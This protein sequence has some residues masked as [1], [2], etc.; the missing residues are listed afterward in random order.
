M[1]IKFNQS[2]RN[3]VIGSGIMMSLTDIERQVAG[4]SVNVDTITGKAGITIW[5]GSQPTP[6]NII[7]NWTSYNS[8]FLCH[9]Q[10]VV[11]IQSESYLAGIGASITLNSAGSTMAINSSTASWG[12]IWPSN[13]SQSQVSNTSITSTKFIVV[14]VSEIGLGGVIML[15]D[16]SIITGNTYNISD[17][18]ILSAGGSN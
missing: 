8:S 4:S 14:S 18:I 9:W 13:P 3:I 12:I 16:T 7:S 6:A 11:L 17:V 2:M 10:D 5:N 15:D 1:T